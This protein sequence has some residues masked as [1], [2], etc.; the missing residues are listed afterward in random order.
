MKVTRTF[1]ERQLENLNRLAG[2]PMESYTNKGDGNGIV[3]QPGNY[4]LD[5]AYGGY[6][7]CR[8]TGVDGGTADVGNM[9]YLSL[10]VVS[11]HI[12]MFAEGYRAAKEAL[13]PI[14][15]NV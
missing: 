9:G 4:H 11:N 14:T 10:A 6:K 1:V 15:T 7:F 13:A 12:R 8:M 2:T 3:S 5:N